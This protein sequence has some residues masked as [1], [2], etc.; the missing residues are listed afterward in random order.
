MQMNKIDQSYIEDLYLT[1]L[2]NFGT[3]K[4]KEHFESDI[5][6]NLTSFWRKNALVIIAYLNNQINE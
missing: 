2:G 4:L 5:S 6:R 3:K 1:F